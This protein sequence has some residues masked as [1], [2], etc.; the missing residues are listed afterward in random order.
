M[1]KGRKYCSDEC[2]FRAN[3]TIRVCQQCGKEFHKASNG[4]V[5]K[6]CSNECAHEAQVKRPTAVC[7][8]CGK[9]YRVSRNA[10][11]D[12]CSR[13]CQWASMRAETSKCTVCGGFAPSGKAYC[14]ERCK[15]YAWDKKRG[16]SLG[17]E[18]VFEDTLEWMERLSKTAPRACDLCGGEYLPAAV[19]QVHCGR[20]AKYL[21]DNNGDLRI[22]R[23]GKPDLSITLRK[24]YERDRGYCRGCGRHIEFV[25]DYNS[26]DYPSIDH[27]LPI[28]KGGTHTWDNVQLMCR[29]CNSLKCDEVVAVPSRMFQT[30]LSV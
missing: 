23:N 9:E 15:A 14:S 17:F 13:E 27:I 25:D 7:K 1:P 12:Y 30:R 29:G 8:A 10:K 28:S 3:G 4:R 21:R 20:C 18:K 22:Y 11:G 2:W 24:L 5:P 16:D 6:Y 19:N 26:D